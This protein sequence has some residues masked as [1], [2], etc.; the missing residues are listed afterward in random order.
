MQGI[1][2]LAKILK[3]TDPEHAAELVR[4]KANDAG[5]TSFAK[6]DAIHKALTGET[7]E[8]HAVRTAKEGESNGVE[9]TS[10]PAAEGKPAG[11]KK[12][13]A[14]PKGKAPP[15]AKAPPR[16]PK[17]P[18]M[19]PMPPMGDNGAPMPPMGDRAGER[20]R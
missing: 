1:Q 4:E 12:Q 15:A 16:K 3:A 20:R 14:L 18:A 9:E 13:P 11:A 19:P 6:L 8:E 17:P 5:G 2:G 7:L 10:H